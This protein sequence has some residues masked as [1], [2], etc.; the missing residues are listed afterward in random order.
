MKRKTTRILVQKREYR[1]ENC[2]SI[3]TPTEL[4]LKLHPLFSPRD[5]VLESLSEEEVDEY[6]TSLLLKSASA[7][8]LSTA[9]DYAVR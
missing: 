8:L 6:S 5:V 9:R 3:R 1:N 7:M 2:K 4:W